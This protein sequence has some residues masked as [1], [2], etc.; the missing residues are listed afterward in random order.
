MKLQ[1][2]IRE[3]VQRPRCGLITDIDGTISHIVENPVDGEVT[4]KAKDSLIKLAAKLTVVGALSGRAAMDIQ[5]RVGVP[6]M[7]YVGNH[8]MERW[9]EGGVVIPENVSQYRPNIAVARDFV[10]KSAFEGVF[11]EDKGATLSVHYRQA[12]DPRAARERLHPIIHEAIKDQNLD[13][14]EGRMIYEI[15]PPVDIDK[16][17][18]FHALIDEFA[19]DA[20]L[21]IGDDTTDADAFRVARQLRENKACF[22][23]G[24]GV[25]APETPQAVLDAADFVVLGVEGVEVLLEDVLNAAVESSI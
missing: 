24:I 10:L 15:R 6:N 22:A 7:I 18:A 9:Q 20:A 5:Q 19:L 25:K 23:F 1:E 13:V 2:M 3:W 8:G 11:V 12:D 4:P 21:Y 16:G 17:S 14:F